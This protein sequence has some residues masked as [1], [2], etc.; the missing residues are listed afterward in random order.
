MLHSR[1][2]AMNETIRTAPATQANSHAGTGRYARP[3]SPWAAAGD[4][5]IAAVRAIRPPVRASARVTRAI[6]TGTRTA[7]A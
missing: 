5:P 3:T 2:S 1:P 7:E 6:D 4:G